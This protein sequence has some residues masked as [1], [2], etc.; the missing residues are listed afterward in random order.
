MNPADFEF[1]AKYLAYLGSH[2]Y[3][4]KFYEF[5]QGHDPTQTSVAHYKL[6][7]IFNSV[8]DLSPYTNPVFRV[9]NEGR[10]LLYRYQEARKTPL[11]YVAKQIEFFHEF[12][13]RFLPLKPVH[14]EG[15]LSKQALIK[16]KRT[17]NFEMIEEILEN[18]KKVNDLRRSKSELVFTQAFIIEHLKLVSLL[19]TISGMT[20]EEIDVLTNGKGL[21]METQ[22]VC[23]M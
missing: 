8:A 17:R 3:T 6:L 22:T 15:P 23:S 21:S 2:V 10:Q 7:S 19:K 5:V 4:N 12:F 13:C 1:N 16:E 14:T 11:H 9:S 20:D 18:L